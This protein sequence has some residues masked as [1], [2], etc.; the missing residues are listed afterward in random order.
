MHSGMVG[1]DDNEVLQGP[2]F[3]DSPSSY[4]IPH[5]LLHGSCSTAAVMA[6]SLAD[7]GAVSL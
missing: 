4:A 6:S 3:W 1:T 5:A 7:V 2:I